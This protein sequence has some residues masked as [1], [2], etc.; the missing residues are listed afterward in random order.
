MTIKEK[1]E[2]IVE[3]IKFFCDISFDREQDVVRTV[4][5]ALYEIEMKR[6]KETD[7]CRK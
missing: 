6:E 1:A 4:A 5:C 2:Y 7:Q 3:E